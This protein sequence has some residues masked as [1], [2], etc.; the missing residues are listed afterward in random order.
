MVGA[1]LTTVSPMAGDKAKG[2][3][4]KWFG[5]KWTDVKTGQPC[6]RAGS[7]KGTRP[8]P[9][10]RPAATAASMSSSE[11]STNAARKKGPD[12]ISWTRTPSGKKKG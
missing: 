10:C 5:E 8:Y 4:G 3:L 2:G 1:A 7:E 11:K 12:R 9:A 6:G